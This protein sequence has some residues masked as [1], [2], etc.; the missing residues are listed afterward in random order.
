MNVGV[1]QQADYHRTSLPIASGFN[2]NWLK[3]S[4]GGNQPKQAI[5]PTM[6]FDDDAALSTR[7][8]FPPSPIG[9]D[10]QRANAKISNATQ[11]NPA[12]KAPKR[13]LAS[14]SKTPRNDPG[15]MHISNQPQESQA[16]SSRSTDASVTVVDGRNP[17]MPKGGH[18]L[19]SL[20]SVILSESNRYF[21]TLFNALFASQNPFED[22]KK[23]SISFLTIS[24][25][26]FAQVWPKLDIQLEADDT[27]FQIVSL[28][29]INI[30][31]MSEF[32]S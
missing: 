13:R 18:R 22:F 25:T 20:P 23:T 3:A 26:A 7:P 27:L 30:L 8:D 29:F 15:S 4:K 21:A 1:D 6:A 19:G 9:F 16:R 11:H 24:R 17:L 12:R 2:P 10:R 31:N 14:T 5:Q 32:I 28:V